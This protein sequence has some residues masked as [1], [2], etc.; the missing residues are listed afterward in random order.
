MD[1]LLIYLIIGTMIAIIT[2]LRLDSTNETDD[3]SFLDW[4]MIII[5]WPLLLISF[6]IYLGKGEDDEV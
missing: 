5:V 3:I 6:V 4:I 2:Y 1:L